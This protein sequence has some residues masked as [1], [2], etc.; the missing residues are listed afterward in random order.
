MPQEDQSAVELN[1]VRD[2][3][4]SIWIA[5][6]LAFVLRA[7]FIEAFVIPTGSM[8]PRLMGEH[9]DLTCP[10]CDY[11]YAFGYPGNGGAKAPPPRDKRE[12]V[13]DDAT[14]PNC[15]YPFR[16]IGNVGL[17]QLV[18]AGDRVLVMKYLY[19][20]RDP[21]P[22]D[23]V[24]FK[25]PQNNLENYIKRLIGLPGETL[26]IVHGDVYVQNP[27][28]PADLKGKSG[29]HIRRKPPKAQEAIW[30]VVFD[31]DFRPE[32]GSI[33]H[34]KEDGNAGRW[35][36][37]EDA[38]GYFG[39][40]F[41][42]K[43]QGPG[44]LM[45]DA[46]DRAFLPVYGYNPP[47]RGYSAQ[48]DVVSDLKL[49]AAFVPQSPDATLTLN[50]SSFENRFQASVQADGGFVVRYC[51]KLDGQDWREWGRGQAAFGPT[52]EGRGHEI[53]LAHVDFR[54][55]L[56]IDG[57]CVFQ[58]ID[59][60]YSP[61]HDALKARMENIARDPIPAPSVRIGGSGGAF[62]LWHVRLMRD[63]FYTSSRVQ[64]SLEDIPTNRYARALGYKP[65]GPGWAVTGNPLV[66]SEDSYFV[67]GDNSPA[68]LDGRGW[69]QAAPTLK[70]WK[71]PER[72][73]PPA[74]EGVG[75]IDE[76]V[77]ERNR[78]DAR[79]LLGTVPKYNM[80]GKALFVYWPAGLRPPGLDFLPLVPNAGEMRLIR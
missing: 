11:A 66:L 38:K 77:T 7:F 69:Y 27:Q 50:L 32:K 78:A 58:S 44:D 5:I 71:H 51:P 12:M 47:G 59:E 60:K 29:W 26:E 30:Q 68:S 70:L 39:R 53:A 57:Q 45:L 25:N 55:Q 52:P 20:F 17:Q 15:G 4:E 37:S 33:K 31:N 23:V 18:N 36:F 40:K 16:K 48:L 61:D 72:E 42:F 64:G 76:K 22:W 56:W 24:V 75:P 49:S 80:I 46:T 74:F 67:L 79:Y 34:W 19:T 14:C 1:T 8:A 10:N 43:G 62:D 63:V 6:V 13:P 65:D 73:H 3:A 28:W 41:V 21:E 35:D 9:W 54:V 2:T